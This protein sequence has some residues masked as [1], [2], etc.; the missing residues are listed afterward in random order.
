ML[1][2]RKSCQREAGLPVRASLPPYLLHSQLLIRSDALHIGDRCT[3]RSCTRG[4]CDLCFFLRGQHIPETQTH[5]LLT[6]PFV[7]PVQAAILRASLT[8]SH[9]GTHLP[10]SD[11]SLLRKYRLRVLFGVTAYEQNRR[12][13]ADTDDEGSAPAPSLASITTLSAVANYAILRRR[14]YNAYSVECPLQHTPTELMRTISLSLSQIS[15]AQ[16]TLAHSTL[17]T[18]YTRYEGWQP[19][20][21]KPD[22]PTTAWERKWLD[23]GLVRDTYPRTTFAL[24]PLLDHYPTYSLDDPQIAARLQRRAEILPRN[25]PH[26]R[27]HTTTAVLMLHVQRQQVLHCTAGMLVMLCQHCDAEC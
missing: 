22:H 17:N 4:I 23:S 2:W 10:A 24:K 8:A 3:K 21:A 26:A 14:H 1:R 13:D 9:P 18:I 6:C 27:S 5:V 7:Q 25:P 20:P 19:D 11:S 16:R 12:G 15:T